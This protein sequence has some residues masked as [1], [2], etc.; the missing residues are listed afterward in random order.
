MK[1]TVFRYWK[2][3]QGVKHV[4]I[5][6]CKMPSRAVLEHDL[7]RMFAFPPKKRRS[8][9]DRLDSFRFVLYHE[10]ALLV[11][12]SNTYGR[13]HCTTLLDLLS[14]QRQPSQISGHNGSRLV[15]HR[16]QRGC[17]VQNRHTT[18][19]PSQD[20][21]R[22]HHQQS[23]K[24]WRQQSFQHKKVGSAKDGWSTGTTMQ[25]LVTLL[26]MVCAS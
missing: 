2:E 11:W 21:P 17:Q 8:W 18:R 23:Q 6:K 3:K 16:S 7:Q 9:F 1:I 15:Q 24:L 19:L 12:S 13:I 26:Q 22:L 20:L 10:P 5:L 4:T 25:P 14:W